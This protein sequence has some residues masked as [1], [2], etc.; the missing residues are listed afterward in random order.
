MFYVLLF[1][2]KFGMRLVILIDKRIGLG[3]GGLGWVWLGVLG[4]GLGLGWDWDLGIINR[5]T[6]LIE[7][8]LDL[9]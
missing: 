8:D 2:E 1:F 4:L 3:L 9:S 7:G 5:N 6:V